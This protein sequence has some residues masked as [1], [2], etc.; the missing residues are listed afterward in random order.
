[1]LEWFLINVEKG[2]VC[3][4]AQ[5][6]DFE[7]PLQFSPIKRR[8]HPSVRT[9]VLLIEEGTNERATNKRATNETTTN[10]TS[11]ATLKKRVSTKKERHHQKMCF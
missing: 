1:L 7:G 5:I 6:N 8:F 4:N 9:D 10:E 3:I 2:L 11:I